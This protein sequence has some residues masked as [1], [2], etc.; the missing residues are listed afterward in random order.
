MRTL[1]FLAAVASLVAAAPEAAEA[2]S[3]SLCS[4]GFFTPANGAVVPA[5]LPGIHWRPVGGFSTSP[6]DPSNV[7]LA[8]AATPGTPIPFTATRLPDGAY[9]LVPDQPLTPGATYLL[10]DR[11][12]CAGMP[13]GPSSTFLVS[14]PAPLPARLGEL[15]EIENLVG[16]LVVGSSGGSCSS[17][18][19]AHQ[20]DL[21]LELGVEA[22]AW[23]DAL[24][25]ETLVDGEVWRPS[26]SIV[27]VVPPGASWR[28][29]GA[30]RVYQVC[31]TDDEDIS[32]GLAPGLHE[33]V[34]RATLPGSGAVAGS[35]SLTVELDCAEAASPGDQDEADGG[36]DA[37]G[38]G[39]SG[40]LVLGVLA[41]IV[42]SRRRGQR[43]APMPMP[44]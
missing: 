25:F 41:G 28:G 9:V 6:G 21:R 24:H 16:P 5:N 44:Q 12:T 31:E 40:C 7:V 22:S 27:A 20:I 15:A 17:P 26:S 4:P 39:S 34:L 14:D 37:G 42:G 10:G 1:A 36:C 29:R 38:S 23:R 33:V 32:E 43:I 30:D 19:E 8:N 11:S 35:S 18:I 13:I 3:P 2:C